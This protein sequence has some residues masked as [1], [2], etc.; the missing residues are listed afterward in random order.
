MSCWRP[1]MFYPSWIIHLDIAYASVVF[2]CYLFSLLY[3]FYWI[4]E[5][6]FYSP[7]KS[8]IEGVQ[9]RVLDVES[10][11]SGPEFINDHDNTSEYVNLFTHWFEI[12][13]P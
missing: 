1:S 7:N 6:R 4:L 5:R 9:E 10:Q 8:S 11:S 13:E 12:L 3:F 2:L